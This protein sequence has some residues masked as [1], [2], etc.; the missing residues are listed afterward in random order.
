MFTMVQGGY[1]SR[2]RKKGIQEQKGK[3]TGTEERGYSSRD[4]RGDTGA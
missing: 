3:D 4:I 1:R 2:E